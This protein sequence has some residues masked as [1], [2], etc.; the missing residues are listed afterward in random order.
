MA[1][2]TLKC[3]HLTP[4]GL[5]EFLKLTSNACAVLWSQSAVCLPLGSLQR[6]PDHL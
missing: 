2:N 3:N 1:M 6:S 4:L 5:K